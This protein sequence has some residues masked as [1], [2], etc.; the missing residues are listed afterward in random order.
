MVKLFVSLFGA[1][2]FVFSL[3]KHTRR[4]KSSLAISQAAKLILTR[5]SMNDAE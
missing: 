4:E 1:L 5:K 2:F 3:N